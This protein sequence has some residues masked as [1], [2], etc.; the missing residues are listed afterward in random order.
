MAF[1]IHSSLHDL[2]LYTKS[3][4]ILYSQVISH[5]LVFLLKNLLAPPK[6]PGTTINLPAPPRTPPAPPLDPP[7]PP[8]KPPEPPPSP[9]AALNPPAPPPN[10][11]APPPSPAAPPN[12]R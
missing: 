6:P 9:P 4:S 3:L 12:K 10:P 2:D 7:T 8:P 11:P 5:T 1:I